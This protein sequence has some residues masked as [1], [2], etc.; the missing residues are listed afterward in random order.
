[1]MLGGFLGFS[2]GAGLSLAQGAMWPTVL[3]RASI[4]SYIAGALMRWWG[5]VWIENLQQAHQARLL[6]PAKPK[7]VTNA[8]SNP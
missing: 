2:L 5:R 7:P 8:K 4:A 1:M 6:A 3:L